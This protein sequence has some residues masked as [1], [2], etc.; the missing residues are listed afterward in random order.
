M[1]NN[2]VLAA[3]LGGLVGS[4]PSHAG[5]P[6]QTEDAGIIE[7]RHCELESQSQRTR[8]AG[9]SSRADLIGLA[10]GVG[11][12]SQI[13]LVVG[14]A[15]E[16]GTRSRTAQLGGK[17]RLW[18]GDAQRAPALVLAWSIAHQRESAGGWQHAAS[19][20]DLVATTPLGDASVVHLNL[21]HARDEAA[22]QG[23]TSWA[24]A[25]EHDGFAIGGLNW[26]PMAEL[27]GDDRQPPWA[28]VAL[29]T[30]LVAERLYLGLSYARQLSGDKPRLLTAGV[31]FAF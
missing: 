29:R 24:A 21:G 17:S 8:T 14:P 12:N 22:R 1:R 27:Y 5:P 28:G 16:D 23:A 13:G 30:T 6:L 15:R 3:L 19:S 31:K 4:A 25:V 7:A 18:Q 11:L 2:L 9:Q 26:A 10:C 20:I